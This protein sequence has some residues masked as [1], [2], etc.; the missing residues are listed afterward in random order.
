MDKGRADIGWAKPTTELEIEN[1]EKVW[2]FEKGE[3]RSWAKHGGG[4]EGPSGKDK[5]IQDLKDR[6]RQAK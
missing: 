2:T 4:E 6:L 5:E 1:E 3:K